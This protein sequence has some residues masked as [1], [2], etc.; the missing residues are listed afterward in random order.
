M[1]EGRRE[2]KHAVASFRLGT[3]EGKALQPQKYRSMDLHLRNTPHEDENLLIALK[4][5]IA[6]AGTAVLAGLAVSLLL[7]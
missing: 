5:F 7:A 6:L 1:V 4:G 3:E 2:Q